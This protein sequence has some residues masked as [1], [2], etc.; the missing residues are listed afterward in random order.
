MKTVA[1]LLTC[2]VL[3]GCA[4]RACQ[5][6]RS[7]TGQI[8][9]LASPAPIQQPRVPRS[10]LTTGGQLYYSDG[11]VMTIWKQDGSTD[12]IYNQGR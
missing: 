11:D 9:T 5:G 7:Y 1:I 12:Y 4:N 3:G 10:G 8:S 6:S 2:L